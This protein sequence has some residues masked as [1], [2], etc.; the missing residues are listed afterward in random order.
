MFKEQLITLA[1]KALEKASETKNLLQTVVLQD[2]SIKNYL[3]TLQ[4]GAKWFAEQ[5]FDNFD[6]IDEK[7]I[8]HNVKNIKKSKTSAKKSSIKNLENIVSEKAI[9]ISK[10]IIDKKINLIDDKKLINGKKTLTYIMWCLNLAK[11][12]DVNGLSI[13][14]ISA[15]LFKSCN[16]SLYPIN[17]SL[18]INKN[19]SLISIIDSNNKI[20]SLSEEGRKLFNKHFK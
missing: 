11:K 4:K 15:L 9:I 5:N 10:F 6:N 13:H 2:E 3:K 16:I 20:Y 19:S 7:P 18:V 12:A 17:I 8:T 1:A 14:D